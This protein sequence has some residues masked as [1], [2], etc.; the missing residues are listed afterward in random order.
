MK[1]VTLHIL[2][3]L[4]SNS[5]AL[6]E[7]IEALYETFVL[8]KAGSGEKQRRTWARCAL[9]KLRKQG[10]V[11]SCHGKRPDD[12]PRRMGPFTTWAITDL[13]RDFLADESQ[14]K[15]I[16]RKKVTPSEVA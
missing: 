15:I 1:Y 3:F 8:S 4:N 13:G 6:P 11:E 10:L 9:H 7:A 14:H 2:R 12:Y 16:R 5:P